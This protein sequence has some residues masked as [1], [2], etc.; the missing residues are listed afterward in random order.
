V[1]L[2]KAHV[3]AGNPAQAVAAYEGLRRSLRE[4]LGTEPSVELEAV[5][6]QAAGGRRSRPA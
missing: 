6:R 4:E 1:L 5:F 2:M 3:A